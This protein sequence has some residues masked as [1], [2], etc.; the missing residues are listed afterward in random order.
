MELKGIDLV[1]VK[2]WVM[3]SLL[4]TVKPVNYVTAN[5]WEVENNSTRHQVEFMNKGQLPFSGIHDLVDHIAGSNS[6][7]ITAAPCLKSLLS[8]YQKKINSSR[9]NFDLMVSYLIGALLD[10]LAQPPLY[11]SAKHTY[12]INKSVLSLQ[13]FGHRRCSK[14]PLSFPESLNKLMHHLRSQG[15]DFYEKVDSLYYNFESE[16]E[17]TYLV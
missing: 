11:G 17:K 8:I 2:P 7:G 1:I 3:S 14:I 15:K 10:D 5:L 4:A 6:K 16:L 12:L 13:K 9:R